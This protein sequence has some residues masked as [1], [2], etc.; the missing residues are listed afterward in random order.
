MSPPAF[1]F[2]PL[3]TRVRETQPLHLSLH[4]AIPMSMYAWP[5]DISPSI[6]RLPSFSGWPASSKPDS[7]LDAAL[8]YSPDS[9]SRSSGQN[10]LSRLIPKDR[11]RRSSAHDTAHP[12]PQLERSG[13]SSSQSSQSSSF[14][15]SRPEKQ[16]APAP[17]A[18][19]TI[20]SDLIVPGATVPPPTER[21]P[22]WAL[23][24]GVG[25]LHGSTS[26][27]V[28]IRLADFSARNLEDES[29]D[30][31]RTTRPASRSTGISIPRPPS[32]QT[33]RQ[34]SSLDSECQR[35]KRLG[36]P[37]AP[38]RPITPSTLIPPASRTRQTAVGLSPPD[39]SSTTSIVMGHKTSSWPSPLS[40]ASNWR[41]G[42]REQM[43]DVLEQM[44]LGTEAVD[45]ADSMTELATSVKCRA[46][47]STVAQNWTGG[48]GRGKGAPSVLTLL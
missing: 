39:V 13:S 4:H 34:A 30:L 5:A 18:S 17:V 16:Y 11:Q 40:K 27:S 45:L 22:L 10:R 48:D 46:P 36:V 47:N 35:V 42:R 38:A 31:G 1:I 8:E 41:K 12:P 19:L 7:T 44:G 15:S 14:S 29:V 2:S 24:P 43:E 9:T 6:P 32:Q 37:V 3:E 28:G 26:A 23:A 25:V 21:I 20:T 33:T